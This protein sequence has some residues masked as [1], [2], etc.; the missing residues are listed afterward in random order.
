M[1]I[2]KAESK[3]KE[4]RKR[5]QD[6]FQKRDK[7]LEEDGWTEANRDTPTGQRALARCD[8]IVSWCKKMK[9]TKVHPQHGDMLYNRIE[10]KN[11]RD[12][13]GKQELSTT[14]EKDGK[15]ENAEHLSGVSSDD[16]DSGSSDSDSEASKSGNAAVPPNKQPN[17]TST[18]ASALGNVMGLIDK[19]GGL[20]V[21][22]EKWL[23]PWSQQL[24]EATESLDKA[25]DIFLKALN[26]KS[27]DPDVKIAQASL[28]KAQSLYDILAPIKKT[29][30]A[31]TQQLED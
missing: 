9:Q 17:V 29:M 11:F 21:Q 20:D 30:D 2:R 6:N 26:G 7:I 12:K 1:K 23:V 14:L 3:G 22:A 18:D 10:Y 19:I 13:V 28:K 15:T 4:K 16:S 27:P 31:A 8:C 5:E 24:T 25:K